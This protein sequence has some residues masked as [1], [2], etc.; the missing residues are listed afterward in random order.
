MWFESTFV[1]SMLEPWEKI[2]LVCLFVVA[3]MFVTSAI[4]KYLP[5]HVQIMSQRAMYYIYGQEGDPRLLWQWLGI[6]SGSEMGGMATSTMN[7]ARTA[8]KAGSDL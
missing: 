6:G 5:R 8:V 4:M 1:L 3:W 7:T 2:M